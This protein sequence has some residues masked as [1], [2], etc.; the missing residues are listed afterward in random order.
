MTHSTAPTDTPKDRSGLLVF[1]TKIQEKTNYTSI[2]AL[3]RGGQLCLRPQNV[4]RFVRIQLEQAQ[5]ADVSANGWPAVALY[6]L[7]RGR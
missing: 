2:T 5:L 4:D 6:A 7:S 1:F 3:R